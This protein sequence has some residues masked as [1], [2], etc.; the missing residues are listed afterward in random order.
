[1]TLFLKKEKG[2]GGGGGALVEPEL[3]YDTQS[4]HTELVRELMAIKVGPHK[5]V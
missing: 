3:K 1:M 2:N 5:T 4:I